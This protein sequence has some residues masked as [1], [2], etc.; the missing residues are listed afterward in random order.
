[1]EERL[2]SE[3]I[4]RTRDAIR[5]F[6]YSQSTF[7]QYELVWRGLSNYFMERHQTLFSKPLAQQYLLE[8]RAKWKTGLILDFAHFKE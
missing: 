4:E 1:M 3:L 7:Y 5:S 2:L 6:E 8:S